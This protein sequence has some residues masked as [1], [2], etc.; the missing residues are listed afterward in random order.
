MTL[1]G[2][3]AA[4]FLVL[5]LAAVALVVAMRGTPKPPLTGFTLYITQT[6]YPADGAPIYTATKVRR[7]KHDGSWKIET[8]Y[9]NGRVDIGYGEPNRGVFALDQKNQK[10][11]YLSGSSSR[12]LADIDWRTQPGF[13]GEETIL[14]YKTYR[15]HSGDEG[16]YVDSYMCPE[17]QGY[18]L[19]VVT[20][21]GRSKTIF[22]VTRVVLG[23]PSFESAPDLP[24]S[25]ERFEQKTKPYGVDLS[26]LSLVPAFINDT[27]LHNEHDLLHSLNIFQRITRHRDDIGPLAG[28]E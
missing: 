17:L 27:V 7:Q 20:G 16:N 10:L 25:T 11:E 3:L 2:I 8:T 23:E 24:I 14:G 21:N 13:T 18:P 19:R 22:E 9:A 6:S 1:K 15:I 26:R 4:A 28:R 5:S 12:P